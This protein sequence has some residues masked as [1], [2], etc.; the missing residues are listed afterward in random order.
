MIKR[1]R[2]GSYCQTIS[3]NMWMIPNAAFW[4][5]KHIYL[6]ISKKLNE[7]WHLTF[8][9]IWNSNRVMVQGV[10]FDIN[11]FIFNFKHLLTSRFKRFIFQPF[12]NSTHIGS[13]FLIV[14]C[15]LVEINTLLSFLFIFFSLSQWVHLPPTAKK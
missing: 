13:V 4:R 7:E 12:I 15:N 2:F 1:G 8:I 14:A 3:D 9:R 6:L 10:L 11:G 5:R